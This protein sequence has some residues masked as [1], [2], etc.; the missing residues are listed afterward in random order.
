MQAAPRPLQ[1]TPPPPPKPPK[2]WQL[3]SDGPAPIVASLVAALLA[4]H[5]KNWHIENQVGRWSLGRGWE[6]VG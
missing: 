5:V 4:L 6:G 1:Q 2:P 3:I